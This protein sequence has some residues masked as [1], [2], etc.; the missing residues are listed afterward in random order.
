MRRLW[1]A[2]WRGSMRLR[3]HASEEILH[4]FLDP[5]IAKHGS[6]RVASRCHQQRT[7]IV[8]TKAESF[9]GKYFLK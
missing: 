3:Q 9:L 2:K 7:G 5:T 6:F 1:L 4:L 8:L